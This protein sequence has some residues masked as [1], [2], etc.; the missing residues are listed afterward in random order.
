MPHHFHSL[1]N[2][3]KLRRVAENNFLKINIKIPVAMALGHY[4]T[5]MNMVIEYLPN[6]RDAHLT[7]LN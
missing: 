1:Y 5:T 4:A 7:L 6:V 3:K 2:F